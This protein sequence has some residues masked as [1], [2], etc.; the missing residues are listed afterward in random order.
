M[1]TTTAT[2]QK[3]WQV[4]SQTRLNSQNIA[5]QCQI[6]TKIASVKS[7]HF[8]PMPPSPTPWKHEKNLMGVESGCIENKW[9]KKRCKDKHLIPTSL[10]K[11]IFSEKH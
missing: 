9:I 6:K 3:N 8:F 11:Q 10:R 4:N 5:T 1:L 2:T 7:T